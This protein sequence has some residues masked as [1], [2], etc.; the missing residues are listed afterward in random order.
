MLCQGSTGL[1]AASG[2]AKKAGSGT[3][4]FPRGF[5]SLA[6]LEAIFGK[7]ASQPTMGDFQKEMG[8]YIVPGSHHWEV[9]RVRE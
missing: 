9:F 3:A 6:A 1:G 5:E 7:I 8:P 2:R 4:S